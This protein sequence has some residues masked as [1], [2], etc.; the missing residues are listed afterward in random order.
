[1]NLVG[2]SK[3]FRDYEKM[4]VP[5]RVARTEKAFWTI[6]L[7]G[8]ILMVAGVLVMMKSFQ[9]GILGLVL[10]LAGVVG[11][12]LVTIW[13]HIRLALYEIILEMRLRT[14]QGQ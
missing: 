11:I 1:M 14:G 5:S 3:R 10:L 7:G 9:H 6:I 2:W 13:A 4:D 12:S 8:V